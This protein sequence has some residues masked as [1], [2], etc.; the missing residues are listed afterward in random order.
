MTFV[1]MSFTAKVLDIVFWKIFVSA[2]KNFI[3]KSAT[4][5]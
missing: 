4:G 1:S 3:N 2:I 5:F